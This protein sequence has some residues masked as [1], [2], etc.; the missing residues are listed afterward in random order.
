MGIKLVVRSET[1]FLVLPLS[2]S[3]RNNAVS[4]NMHYNV[5]VLFSGRS[6]SLI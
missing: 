1:S 2:I 3:T 6:L 4:R 5:K